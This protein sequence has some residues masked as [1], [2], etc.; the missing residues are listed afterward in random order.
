MYSWDLLYHDRRST[1]H[2]RNKWSAANARTNNSRDHDQSRQCKARAKER[3]PWICFGQWYRY[4]LLGICDNNAFPGELSTYTDHIRCKQKMLADLHIYMSVHNDA[5]A[6]RQVCVLVPHEQIATN[7]A[8]SQNMAYRWTYIPNQNL[9]WVIGSLMEANNLAA[10]PLSQETLHN[11][12][13]TFFTMA[14]QAQTMEGTNE[15][16][17]IQGQ[18]KVGIMIKA[19][20]VR[21]GQRKESP[22]FVWVNDIDALGICDNNAF[23]GE[24][25]TYTDHIRCK[26]KMLADLYI[27]LSVHND[28]IAK[29]QVCVLLPY[30][31]HSLRRQI[32]NIVPHEQ[33]ATNLAHS[34]NMARR[35]TYIP[36]QNLGWVIGSLMEA[37]NLA[38]LPLSQETSHT[39]VGTIFT[40]T[41]QA[42]KFHTD[43]FRRASIKLYKISDKLSWLISQ[44][45]DAQKWR[46]E[47]E[48][49]VPTAFPRSLPRLSITPYKIFHSRIQWHAHE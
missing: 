44:E 13:G 40:M 12:V 18:T 35:W 16:Q 21:L 48:V 31:I 30:L 27:Y 9:G 47:F 17:P 4:D 11:T 7:L 29:R 39:T 20:N 14:G 49:N 15:V 32:R 38:A 42:Q 1:N 25:S 3:K 41:G 46:S 28:A 22:E 8:H 10:L 2:G 37:N 19:G 34:Q 36:N 23:P 43:C 24:L 33:I 6:K 45:L 26:Q 5:I